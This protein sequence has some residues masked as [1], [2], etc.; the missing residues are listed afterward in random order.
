MRFLTTAAAAA[1]TYKPIKE[2]RV[3]VIGGSIGGCAVAIA[4]KKVGVEKVDVFERSQANDLADRG[5]GIGFPGPIFQQLVQKDM[6]DDDMKFV[7]V[8]KRHWIVEDGTRGGKVA[9][10]HPMLAQLHNWGLLWHQLRKRVDDSDYHAG[11]TVDVGSSKIHQGTSSTS[12][13]KVELFDT[14]QSSLGE[15]DFCIQAEGA[16]AGADN[17]ASYAGYVLWRGSYPIQTHPEIDIGDMPDTFFTP[18][19]ENGH[20]I[21][22]LMPT[23]NSDE[24]DYRMNYAF[25]THTP[26]GLEGEYLHKVT[27]ASQITPEQLEFLNDTVISKVP[28]RF[29]DIIKIPINEGTIS[30]HPILDR[31][32]ETFVTMEGLGLLLGDAGAVLRPHTGSGTTKAVMEAL[33]IEKLA[34]E[35]DATWKTVSEAYQADR[36]GDGVGKVAYGER[37]GRAQVLETPDWKE[38]ASSDFESWLAAQVADSGN[39]MYKDMKKTG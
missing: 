35:P 7:A 38:M 26:P 19:Y 5:L 34:Q 8:Q 14:D 30:I 15:Y 22:Y 31:V 4:L 33:L 21:V 29:Q 39:Y 17:Q 13:A 20:G 12:P 24:G 3:A 37:L 1:L 18:V 32:P 28:R 2:S 16:L 9:Y 23:S 11:V 6:L 27:R 10:Q 36:H 25:Y